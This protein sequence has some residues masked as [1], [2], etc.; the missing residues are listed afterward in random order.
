MEELSSVQRRELDA[1]LCQYRT[2]I[3]LKHALNADAEIAERLPE[4]EARVLASLAA[5]ASLKLDVAEVFG[6]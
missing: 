4:I 3:R 1:V 5:G 6:Q 2:A